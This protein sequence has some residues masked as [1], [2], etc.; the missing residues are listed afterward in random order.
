M[1]TDRDAAIIYAIDKLIDLEFDLRSR[2]DRDFADRTA[3]V[4]RR[5]QDETTITSPW[6]P[7]VTVRRG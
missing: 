7:V 5:L 4:R 6:P 1:M 3:V 2:G